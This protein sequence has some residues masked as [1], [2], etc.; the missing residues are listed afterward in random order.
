VSAEA[1]RQ[2]AAY[3]GGGCRSGEA[4]PPPFTDE[5]V[6]SNYRITFRSIRVRTLTEALLESPIWLA[7]CASVVS[8]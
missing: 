4:G 8:H 2:H 5:V 6:A 1:K 3:A 7:I